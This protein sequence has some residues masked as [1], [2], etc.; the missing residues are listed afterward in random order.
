MLVSP[1]D[2]INEYDGCA[3]FL[4]PLEVSKLTAKSKLTLTLPLVHVVH[5]HTLSLS[6][7]LSLPFQP[8]VSSPLPSSPCASSPLATLFL[9]SPLRTFSSSSFSSDL[10]NPFSHPQFIR[11]QRSPLMNNH[12]RDEVYAFYHLHPHPPPPHLHSPSYLTH[13]RTSLT[14]SLYL[15]LTSYFTPLL[16]PNLIPPLA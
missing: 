3:W 14:H 7:T 13:P 9:L 15:T 16:T 10:R 5:T 4:A 6:Q 2:M 11:N 8:L 12:G 1:T